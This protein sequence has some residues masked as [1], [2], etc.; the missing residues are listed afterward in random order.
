MRMI[1][2]KWRPGHRYRDRMGAYALIVG[3]DGMLLLVDED[4]ELQIPGGGIDP[5]ESPVQALHRE[6]I[7]ETGWRI[8]DPRRIGGYQRFDYLDSVGYWCRVVKLVFAA[9]A[10]RRLGQPTEGWHQPLWMSPG[11]AARK[12]DVSGDRAMVRDAIAAGLI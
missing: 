2:D 12:L 10:V 4:G 11:D 8:A 9:R 3:P 1:Q 5:G 7:E 6:V